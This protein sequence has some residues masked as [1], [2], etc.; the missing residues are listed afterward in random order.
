MMEGMVLSLS[1]V[2][3]GR[4]LCSSFRHSQRPK[5]SKVCLRKVARSYLAL[6]LVFCCPGGAEVPAVHGALFEGSLREP[7]SIGLLLRQLAGRWHPQWY[8]QHAAFFLRENQQ[9]S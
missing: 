9:E 6:E 5:H 2:R 3:P 8:A 7:D 4:G 1:V